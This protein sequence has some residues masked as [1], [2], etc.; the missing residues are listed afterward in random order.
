LNSCD[1]FSFF[2]VFNFFFFSA[3]FSLDTVFGH[4]LWSLA[5]SLWLDSFSTSFTFQQNFENS[6]QGLPPEEDCQ[7][8]K[9]FA[10]FS[11]PKSLSDAGGGLCGLNADI[12]YQ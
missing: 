3:K 1:C 8:P 7:R 9:T 11:P 6:Q 4:S 5:I 10:A 2:G 12:S